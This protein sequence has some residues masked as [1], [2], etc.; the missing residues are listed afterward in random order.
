MNR[1]DYLRF[2][3]R[4]KKVSIKKMAEILGIT[5]TALHYK[6]IGSRPFKESEMKKIASVFKMN[7]EDIFI[8][9]KKVE[10]VDICGIKYIITSEIAKKIIAEMEESRW[11]KIV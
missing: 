2:L 11:T 3:F 9:D 8:D 7:M 6:I 5:D 4:N 1:T 10:V